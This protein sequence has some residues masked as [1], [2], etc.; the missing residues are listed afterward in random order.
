MKWIVLAAAVLLGIAAFADLEISHALV[1]R[2]SIFGK[3]FETVGE[4]PAAVIASFC[5]MALLLLEES[6]WKKWFL[7]AISVI[8]AVVGGYF[9]VHYLKLP[10]W[11][12]VLF[13][14][15]F[16]AAEYRVAL[17]CK[18]KNTE[19]FREAAKIGLKLFFISTV[20]YQ[21]MKLGWGRERYRHMASGG[22]FEGF[23]RWFIPRRLASGN[24]FM[25]FPS[26]HSANAA[27]MIWIVL[28]SKFSDVWKDRETVLKIAAFAWMLLVMLSRIIVG[29][30][31]LSDV[32]MG[33]FVSLAVFYRLCENSRDKF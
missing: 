29:A 8:L 27:M 3:I 6:G 11:T 2:D 23:S 25:S 15:I 21:L 14:V 16:L 19:K 13:A 22:S 9:P 18:D 7:G 30:H 24:E 1:H 26:G 32:T 31:F 17:K 33:A 12:S 20:I 4:I 28:I 10:I 5:A